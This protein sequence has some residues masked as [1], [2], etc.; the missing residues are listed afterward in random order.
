TGGSDTIAGSAGNDT[1]VGDSG[2]DSIIGL[3]GND[4]LVG[5]QGNDSLI[6]QGGKDTLIGGDGDDFMDGIVGIDSVDGGNG[7]DRAGELASPGA[8]RKMVFSEKYNLL[9]LL[10]SGSAVRV[11]DLKTGI[12]ISTRLASNEFTDIDLSPSGDYL[13]AADFG[14]E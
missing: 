9:F 11:V 6:G 14:G 3:D 1:L 13:F 2:D 10:N 7:L 4:S 8:A 5:G 12:A